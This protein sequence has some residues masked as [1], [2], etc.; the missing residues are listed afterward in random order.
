MKTLAILTVRNEGAFLL[1]WLAHHRLTGFTDFLV[2]SNDCTDGSDALLD[3]LAAMGVLAHVANPAPH[4][5][6]PQWSALALAEAHPLRQA[7]DWV[8]VIDIDEFVNVRVGDGTLSDLIGAVPEADCL[9]MTWRLFG[10]AGVVVHEGPVTEAFT[11]AAPENLPWPWRAHLI[12]TLFRNDGAYGKLG[13]HRPRAPVAVRVD[14]VR[15]VDGS[16]RALPR[17]FQKARLFTPPGAAPYG[18]VQLNHYA[19]GSMQNYVL[20]CDRGRANRESST[21][22]LS[23]W[24]DRNFSEVEERSILR[25][26]PAR[27]AMVADWLADPVLGELHHQACLWRKNRFA[28]LMRQDESWRSLYGRLMLTGPSRVLPQKTAHQIWAM[29]AGGED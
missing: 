16:G 28:D 23:Y 9:A 12:K 1:E 14:Q 6:G 2:L 7:A 11:H 13:V 21:F 22:D 19:L 26:A 4:A 5:K 8:A 3:R 27:A 29:G 24:I 15:W 18:L 20:K 10:N 25:H 17:A